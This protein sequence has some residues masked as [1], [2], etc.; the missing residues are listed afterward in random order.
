MGFGGCTEHTALAPYVQDTTHLI[1]STPLPM[2]AM[3]RW[4][5]YVSQCDA[6][7]ADIHPCKGGLELQLAGLAHL[8]PES[9]RAGQIAVDGKRCPGGMTLTLGEHGRKTRVKLTGCTP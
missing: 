8:T 1:H 9:L 6:A 7:I 3:E 5:L 4:P 2:I